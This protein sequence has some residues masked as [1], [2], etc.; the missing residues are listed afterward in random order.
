MNY[1]TNWDEFTTALEKYV[2]PS[3][4]FVFADKA[5]NIGYYAPG[6]IP[7]RSQGDGSVPVPG[8]TDVYRWTG[9][10]PFE[11]L[12]NVYNPEAG[13]VATANNRSVPDD[14]PYFITNDWTPP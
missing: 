10:I 7:I 1:A 9:W 6:K 11:D 5:G 3:Q 14:Y 12:P 8:W 2:A 13:F 4:N